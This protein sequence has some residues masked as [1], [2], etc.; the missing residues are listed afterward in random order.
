MKS[1]FIMKAKLF[2]NKLVVKKSSIHGYGV[3]AGKAIKA[4]EI[5]EE[6]YAI[7]TRGEDDVLE[8]YFFNARGKNAVLTGFGWIYNHSEDANVD[9]DYYS[10]KRLMVFKAA[11]DIK[12]GAEIYIDYGDEWFK[13]RDF[14]PKVVK[15]PKKKSPRKSVKTARRKT[16]A[17]KKLASRKK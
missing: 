7:V 3:F 13:D 15:P 1:K 16:P 12:K 2:Q 17:R 11:E 9:Y 10:K 8:D 14:T 4:G 6:C 5:V